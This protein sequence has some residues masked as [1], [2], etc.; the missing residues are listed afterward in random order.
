M[1]DIQLVEPHGLTATPETATA[2]G[3]TAAIGEKRNKIY[4]YKT[5]R[6]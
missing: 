4:S 6:Q 1:L 2:E 5:T 3:T